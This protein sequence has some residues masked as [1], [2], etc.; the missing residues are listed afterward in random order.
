MG[1]ITGE[2]AHSNNSASAS[3]SLQVLDEEKRIYMIF[4]EEVVK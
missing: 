4:S 1:R 2:L 3:V